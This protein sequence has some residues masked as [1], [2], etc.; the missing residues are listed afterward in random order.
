MIGSIMKKDWSL[1]WPMVAIVTIIQMALAWL[2]YNSGMFGSDLAPRELRQPLTLAWFI[3]IGALAAAVVHQDPVPG[4]DQDWL[5]RPLP[6]TELLLAKLLFAIIVICAPMLALD[7]AQVLAA[8]FSLPAALPVLVYKEV[9]LLICFVIPLMALAAITATMAE[10]LLLGA[11][12]IAI[13]ATALSVNAWLL[14]SEHCP[15]CDTGVSWIQH[16]V[17][18]LGTLFGA[19]VILVA[20]YYRRRTGASRAL[21]GIGTLA[22]V[23]GQLPWSVAFGIQHWLSPV[24]NAAQAIRIVYDAPRLSPLQQEDVTGAAGLHYT[25]AASR[26]KFDAAVDYLQPHRSARTASVLILLPVQIDGLLPDELLLVDRSD[27]SLIGESGLPLYHGFNRGMLDPPSPVHAAATAQRG[28]PLLQ[29]VELPSDVYRNFSGAKLRL[30]LDYSITLLKVASRHVIPARDGVL[31]GDDLGDCAARPEEDG[32]M[33][34]VRCQKVGWT[35]FCLG[36][37]LQGAAD[38]ENPAILQCDPDYRPY[39]P[40]T[41]PV[42][43]FGV[44]IP[45]K[46]PTGLTHYP[47]EAAQLST[48]HLLITVYAVQ[49]HASRAVQTPIIRLMDVRNGGQ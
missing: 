49:E 6:R 28:A 42:N 25:P 34:H 38:Q 22:L 8:G 44:D 17:Q 39:L 31:R 33:I 45:L 48:L 30:R 7:G 36:V 43:R 47:L 26:N 27:V 29:A 3:G 41:E 24:P 1:L 46:D 15:T 21:A 40:T 9:Y 11:T 19:G 23:F 14:G 5:I 16:L 2:A 10:L 12:L 37:N 4:V 32:S 13:F 18:H 20:Q 35:P